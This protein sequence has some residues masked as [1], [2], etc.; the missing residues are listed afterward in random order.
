MALHQQEQRSMT[1]QQ[2]QQLKQQKQQLKQQK[3]QQEQ[4][5]KLQ[6]AETKRLKA[7][8]T[9]HA[10]QS[11]AQDDLRAQALEYVQY[12]SRKQLIEET[13]TNWRQL[14]N[15]HRKI[16]EFDESVVDKMRKL[17]SK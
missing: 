10:A 15:W 6:R 2:K 12:H 16:S 13:G 1:E 8:A 11:T 7:E 3:Q 14:E 9:A 5:Q 4:Q 17:F